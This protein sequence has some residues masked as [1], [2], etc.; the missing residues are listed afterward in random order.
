MLYKG[1]TTS[2]RALATRFEALATTNPE[3]GPRGGG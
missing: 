2:K 1:F 3:G